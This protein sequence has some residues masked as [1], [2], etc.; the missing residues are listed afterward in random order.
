MNLLNEIEKNVIK[1]RS[2]IRF[3]NERIHRTFIVNCVAKECDENQMISRVWKF[4][5]PLQTWLWWSTFALTKR[6]SIVIVYIRRFLLRIPGKMQRMHLFDESDALR[7]CQRNWFLGYF[8]LR[9]ADID[10]G[11]VNNSR[12]VQTWRISWKYFFT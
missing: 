1:K 9:T 11:L 3:F 6:R 7:V 5:N 12:Y 10:N 4:P 8:H 2:R